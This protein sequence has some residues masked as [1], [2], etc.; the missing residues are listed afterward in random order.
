MDNHT[1]RESSNIIDTSMAGE[2]IIN[3]TLNSD[4]GLLPPPPL[5]PRQSELDIGNQKDTDSLDVEG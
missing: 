3:S 2:K 4:L 5:Q 1:K